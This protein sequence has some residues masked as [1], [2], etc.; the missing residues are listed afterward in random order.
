MASTCD[1]SDAKTYKDGGVGFVHTM[2]GSPRRE[3]HDCGVVAL[4]VVLNIPY[5]LSHALFKSFGRKNR[6]YAPW[7]TFRVYGPLK[8]CWVG[9]YYSISLREFVRRYPKGGYF[10][11]L[12]PKS[13]NCHALAVVDGT[14][15]DCG[16]NSPMVRV[17][18]AWKCTGL[19][20]NI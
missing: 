18:L 3:R 5:K 10:L 7:D 8:W 4:S 1:L 20:K 13:F 15:Y 6:G 17:S 9:P 19:K 2:A 11:V 12:R 16:I 14:V